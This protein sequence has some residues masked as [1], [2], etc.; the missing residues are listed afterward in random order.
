MPFTDLGEYDMGGFRAVAVLGGG[1]VAV[2]EPCRTKAGARR[3]V[4][5]QLEEM[6]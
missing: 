6:A 4:K 1:V 5:A 3:D 2:S